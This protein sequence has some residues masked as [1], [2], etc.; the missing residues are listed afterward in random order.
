MTTT[1]SIDLAAADRLRGRS[2]L[3]TDDASTEELSALLAV[4]ER[5]AAL[6][7]AGKKTAAPPARARLRAV[8]RQLDADEVRV[9]G[10]RG[11]ARDAARH[12]GRLVHAGL[13]RRDGGRDGRDARDER[14]R[15]RRAARPDPRRGERLHA[16]REEGHRRLPRRDGRPA[17]RAR[18]EPPV[19]HRPPDADARG[20][21]LAARAVSRRPRRKA[22]RRVVGVF[23]ELRQAALGPAGP[24]HA[25]DALRRARDARA[26]GGLPPHGPVPRVR[27]GAR[28]VFRRLVPDGLLDGRG[29]RGRGRRLSEELGALRPHALARRGEPRARLE[30]DG[31]DR[32]GGPRAKRAAHGTG[33]ATSG[34]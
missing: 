8:L 2:L 11:A 21:L 1:A 16:R 14:A 26:P 12:R 23:A 15:A 28:R 31:R 3:L 32:K 29:V 9:G 10:R 22:H 34:G 30:A 33:S 17:E 7:R 6:D 24:R 27:R 5:F 13:A 19:R 18:R 4:A 25:P 20:P